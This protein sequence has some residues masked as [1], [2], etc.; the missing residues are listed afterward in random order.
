[1]SGETFYFEYNKLDGICF[2]NFLSKLS[3]EYPNSTNLVILDSCG[4]HINQ[5]I[6]IP[7]NVILQYLPSCS[8]ELNPQERIWEELRK[9]LKGK[10]FYTLKSLRKFLKKELNKMTKKQYQSLSFFTYIRESL[11]GIFDFKI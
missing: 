10:T 3:K 4:G 1:M 7:K 9:W 5:E 8:P 11:N 2:E 6:E